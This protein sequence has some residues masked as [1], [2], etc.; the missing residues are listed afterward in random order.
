MQKI[1]FTASKD[2][3]PLQ[4]YQVEFGT[5]LTNVTQLSQLN[6]DLIPKI[7]TKTKVINYLS[8][9][10]TPIEGI[11]TFPIAYDT[12]KKYPLMTIPHGGP[13]ALVKNDFGWMKQFFADQG[14]VVFQPNFRGSIGYGRDIYAGNRN[15]FGETDFEDIMSGIDD[16]IAKGI[17]DEQQLVIG[18]WSYGGYMA[19]WAITQTNR[20]KAAISIAGVSNWV[21]LYGQH[22]FSNRDIGLWEYKYLLID[23]P[24]AYRKASPL[25]FVKNAET[26]LLILHGANDNRSPTLQAWEMYRAMKD[27]QKEVKMMLYPR[28]GHNISNPVQRKSVLNQWLQW[29]DDHL[30][31]K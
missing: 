4:L 10:G 28:A 11:L 2:T 31:R 24:E 25:F 21:S 30:G 26:P 5:Q 22:E 16:L 20:F 7:K 18:G 3:R 6:Q 27:A 17:A 14:Y 1:L 23:N 12:S 8:K 13:D 15:A 9:D 29:S 19:N